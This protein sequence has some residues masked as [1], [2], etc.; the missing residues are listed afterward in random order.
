LAFDEAVVEKPRQNLKSPKV[1]E[2]PS[3][4]GSQ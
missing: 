4:R 1:S 3:Q 2:G